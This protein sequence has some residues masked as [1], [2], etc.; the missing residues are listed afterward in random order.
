MLNRFYFIKVLA[1]T[2][3]FGFDKDRGVPFVRSINISTFDSN[4]MNLIA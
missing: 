2:L 3:T 4:I 1:K